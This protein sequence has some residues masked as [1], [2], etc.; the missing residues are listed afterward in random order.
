MDIG[1]PPW[2][3]GKYDGYLLMKFFSCEEYLEDFLNGKI[4]FNTSDYFWTIENEG[5]ADPDESNEIIMSTD[6]HDFKSMNMEVINGRYC[7]VIRDY[8]KNPEKYVPSTMLTYSPARNRFRKIVCF[9]SA[10]VNT[11]KDSILLPSQN[12]SKAFGKYAVVIP[13]RQSFFEELEKGI[14]N[15]KGI[16]EAQIGFVEYVPKKE[17]RGAYEWGPFKKRYKFSE[18]NELRATFIDESKE[19]VKMELGINLR[20]LAFPVLYE[21]ISE[22]YMK[23]GGLYY[24]IYQPTEEG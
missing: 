13:D 4:F 8:S 18:Q 10:Y 3:Y 19:P 7:A 15:H 12:M 2:E 24:P 17:I 9:Y 23:D 20:H 6:Q 21:D 5:Q 11:K 14:R 1:L 16:K 22:I